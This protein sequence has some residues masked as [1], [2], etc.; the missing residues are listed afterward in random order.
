MNIIRPLLVLILLILFGNAKAQT[1][2]WAHSF[3]SIDLDV[4]Y[5]ILTDADGNVYVS[6]YFSDTVDLDPGAGLLEFGSAGIFDISIQKFDP[7]G[8]LIWAKVFGS[9]GADVPGVMKFD[10]FGNI[11][12]S[13]WFNDSLDFDPGAGTF[14]L[15]PFGDYDAF[16]LKMD[17]DGNFLWAEKFGG[18]GQEIGQDVEFD[19][20]GN[21]V[22]GGSFE[23]IVDFDPGAGVTLLDSAIAHGGFAVKL[24]SD[25]NF[26]SATSFDVDVIDADGNM[27]S[28]N[29]FT[30]TFDFDPGAGTA[31]LTSAGSRDIYIIKLDPAGN[32]RWV[33][34]IGDVGADEARVLD[35]DPAG[36]LILT[37][38]YEGT[39]DYD[40]NSGVDLKTS[41][42]M[43]DLVIQKLDTAG[44]SLWA[45]SFGGPGAEFFNGAY[46]DGLGNVYST[47]NYE[48]TTDFDPGPGIQNYT[49]LGLA[50]AFVLKLNTDGEYEWAY[51]LGSTDFENGVGVHADAMG[52]FYGSGL[53]SLTIDFDPGPGVDNETSNG[54][55]DMYI[56]KWKQS[57]SG[58][59]PSESESPF[60]MTIHPNPMSDFSLLSL[61]GSETEN[62][63]V[64]LHDFQGRLIRTISDSHSNPVQIERGSLPS[65]I[66]FVQVIGENGFSQCK[67]LIIE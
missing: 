38:M 7:D 50:D 3:G 23:G 21:V 28:S 59:I 16:L 29:Y 8:N 12:L 57:L 31:M 35:I 42:G 66:Y 1:L 15:I 41:A 26:I 10:S 55:G 13:G 54:G 20:A 39:V 4:G 24:D 63:T 25:G 47:G 32:F 44:N 22:L 58:L 11:Y 5:T 53:F 61:N 67:K 17:S 36:D 40:P 33:K 30:G 27:Y 51:S 49:V 62:Y 6:A 56:F 64:L 43:K 9:A 46:V 14:S 45:K 2:Q 18:A 60:E 34:Q 65:G 52:N 48:L 37:S 19:P